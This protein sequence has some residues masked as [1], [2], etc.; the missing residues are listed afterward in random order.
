MQS[1]VANPRR[2]LILSLRDHCIVRHS[3]RYYRHSAP[4]IYMSKLPAPSVSMPCKS[5]ILQSHTKGQISLVLLETVRQSPLKHLSI[6]RINNS[7][8]TQKLSTRRSLCRLHVQSVQTTAEVCTDFSR[9]L[10]NCFANYHLAQ[11]INQSIPTDL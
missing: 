8:R 10:Q 11:P 7:V 2:T 9:S 3:L 6:R 1:E 4:I 5:R